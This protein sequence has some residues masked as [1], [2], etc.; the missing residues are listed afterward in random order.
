MYNEQTNFIQYLI[1]LKKDEIIDSIKSNIITFISSP[2]GTG[3]STQ[4]PQYLYEGFPGKILICEPR[5]I[6][7]NSISEYIKKENSNIKVKS[8]DLDLYYKN[9]Y[10]VL[11]ITENHLLNIL[12][13]D[14]LLSKCDILLI[15]EIHERTMKLD[16]ILYYMKYF[17][18]CENNILRN[19]KLIL[20]SATLNIKDIRN[21]FS[22]I[23][24]CNNM[25]I[26]NQSINDKKYEIKYLYEKKNRIIFK[27]ENFDFKY[28][29][30][31]TNIISNIIEY[32]I[33]S[34][35]KKYTINKT[36]LVFLPDFKSILLVK[37]QLEYDFRNLLNIEE[38]SSIKKY[39]QQ[40]DLLNYLENISTKKNKINVILS[41]TLAETC[42]T[43]P[44]CDVVI[45]SGIKK[46]NKYNYFTN[47]YEENIEFISKDSAI[48]RAGRCGR[49]EKKG[50]CY[51]LYTYNEYEKF[52]DFR[53][54]EVEYLN[55][56][57]II[58]KIFQNVRS[59]NHILNDIE[60]KGY[61]DFVSK[62]PINIINVIIEKLKNSFAIHRYFKIT[63]FGKWLCH[64]NM[65]LIT[66]SIINSLDYNFEEQNR[67]HKFRDYEI[68]RIISI[69]ST[70]N[71]I[72]Y[73]LFNNNI[74]MNYFQLHILDYDEPKVRQ[75][76]IKYYCKELT[77]SLI[78]KACSE[79]IYDFDNQKIKEIN[80]RYEYYKLFYELNK[81]Y[82][83]KF[84]FTINKVFQTG[85]LMIILFFIRQYTYIKCQNHYNIINEKYKKH[86]RCPSC[87][88]AKYYYCQ[89]Y[90]LNEK[91]FQIQKNRF[92]K[93]I[94]AINQNDITI[95]KNIFKKIKDYEYDL[96]YWNMIYLNLISKKPLEYIPYE[97]ILTLKKQIEKVDFNKILNEIYNEYYKFYVKYGLFILNNRTILANMFVAKK[98]E[99]GIKLYFSFDNKV[100]INYNYFFD[101]FKEKNN[102]KEITSYFSLSK[103]VKIDEKMSEMG[104]LYYYK[105][106]NPIF[107]EMKN[108]KLETTQQINKLEEINQDYKIETFDNIGLYFF[109]N[110]LKDKLGTNDFIYF[111]N[112]LIYFYKNE[113]E[114]I[115][116]IKNI[117][118]QEKES[119]KQIL[120]Y[121][122]CLKNGCLT[123]EL[124]QG[125]SIEN[126]FDSFSNS[127]NLIYEIIEKNNDN[128]KNY[129]N[130]LSVQYLTWICRNKKIL[131]KRI[132][133]FNNKTLISFQQSE[134]ISFFLKNTDLILK[135]FQFE[136]QNS[137]SNNYTVYY[138]F[139]NKNDT[140]EYIHKTMMIYF[141]RTLQIK[142]SYIINEDETKENRIVYYYIKNKDK[143]NIPE[144]IIVG[145]KIDFN[146][147]ND[148]F[149]IQSKI[150]NSDENY[151]L[152]FFNFCETNH[153]N[154][155]KIPE[156]NFDDISYY[157]DTYKYQILNYSIEKLKLI[158]EYISP[159]SIQLNKFAL[160][161][162][163]YKS[164]DTF[165]NEDEDIYL[166]AKKNFCNISIIFFDYKILIY[167]S[168]ENRNNLKSIIIK[169]FE[170][171]IKDKIIYSIEKKE[172]TLAL[173]NL[174]K[175]CR[176]LRIGMSITKNDFNDIKLEFR[177]ENLY[178]VKKILKGKKKIKNLNP[179]NKLC[180]IC[181]EEFN[182]KNNNNYIQ[183]KICGHYFCVECLKMQI[184]NDIKYLKN[185]PLTCIKCKTYISNNDIFEIFIED[186]E[187]YNNLTR[188]LINCFMLKNK[189]F[190][191][192]P[193]FRKNC[194]YVYNKNNY[195]DKNII[196]CPNCLCKICT[197]CNEM[198]DLNKEH[199][200]NCRKKL[201]SKLNKEDRKWLIENSKNCPI[202]NTPYEKTNGC[203][204]MTC[205]ICNPQIHFCYICGTILNPIDPYIH[206]NNPQ[207]KC[208]QR[209]WDKIEE[210][211]RNDDTILINEE[212]ED[213][214]SKENVSSDLINESQSTITRE[215]LGKINKKNNKVNVNEKKKGNQFFENNKSNDIDI[216]IDY[217]DYFMGNN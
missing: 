82:N 29:R 138:V 187:D 48:Q 200:K 103:F 72:N 4:I 212:K 49:G 60:K 150:Y 84:Y 111:N 92:N 68:Y 76:S 58:L 55:I 203:N 59:V 206:Y 12:S 113:N 56:D 23:L 198:I 2:T 209:L 143:I 17:T 181:L 153:I 164:K 117:I 188:S 120:N 33:N 18:L 168:P 177:K 6:A 137:N 152:K 11:F 53:L 112:L 145:Q 42:L 201:F 178:F 14:P 110:F 159:T 80:I 13:R 79:K 115:N 20:V 41:T 44:N 211:E 74:D 24:D 37:N 66:G 207:L 165:L 22:D 139:F 197:I 26:I 116:N 25:G 133:T 88:L 90:S 43:F 109:M 160:E 184:I 180:E 52:R 136:G 128:N 34:S 202:C 93:I 118:T 156:L 196:N 51:R 194:I 19:F 31:L 67:V 21:Y 15:D 131:Y 213:N 65:D 129:N 123:L 107:D 102:N 77:K 155:I 127:Q 195:P 147:N 158:M 173:K 154:V 70:I 75:K 101:C 190:N 204:H 166:F 95:V 192:C 99:N 62:I 78:N 170:K 96:I 7:C 174:I 179:Y 169:Y 135:T 83:A 151:F 47:I 182:N 148:I 36:I 161:E 50:I 27:N 215:I 61:L 144:N 183:L 54:G 3:K 16:L 210:N 122:Q 5:K 124:S 141:N 119:Y 71:S 191:W 104:N 105:N 1:S 130:R 163:K 126:I 108:K 87:N 193:N 106:I 8:N 125:L 86:N 40:K 97:R 28:I 94:K 216:S 9:Q 189:N 57:L 205:I 142:S 35:G 214:K 63:R 157:D 10:E 45:D 39:E 64:N 98:Y 140:N 81:I 208:Y 89:V 85:E 176:K 132:F 121:R 217:E 134:E 149:Y 199:N 30:Y 114:K 172:E 32:E 91:F 146:E 186:T 171:V 185:I 38:F 46:T 162:I 73:E 175:K 100:N 69:V 167:G